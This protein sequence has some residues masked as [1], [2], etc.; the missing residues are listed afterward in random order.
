[1]TDKCQLQWLHI[2]IESQEFQ[3]D[4][5]T[6]TFINV[7][8]KRHVMKTMSFAVLSI[9][10]RKER[11]REKRNA[12]KCNSTESDDNLD[13]YLNLRYIHR[14]NAT[15][16]NINIQPHFVS[17]VH[18]YFSWRRTNRFKQSFIFISLNRIM[19]VCQANLRIAQTPAAFSFH[20]L[21]ICRLRNC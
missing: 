21:R 4:S 2:R 8:Y 15:T 16:I 19:A 7:H 1:M 12:L 20:N 14:P 11:S 3:L 6:S 18:F 13:E 17:S 9:K 5:R 10:K